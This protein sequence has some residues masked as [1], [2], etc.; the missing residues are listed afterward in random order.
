M[1][2]EFCPKSVWLS[3]SHCVTVPLGLE[4]LGSGEYV[5]MS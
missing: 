2:I 1:G 5:G 3:H 4:E